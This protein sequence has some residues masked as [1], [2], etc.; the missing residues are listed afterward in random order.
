VEA[1]VAHPEAAD[2]PGPVGGDKLLVQG[3]IRH[4]RIA[5]LLA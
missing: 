5:D 4:E 2:N 3:H 1:R